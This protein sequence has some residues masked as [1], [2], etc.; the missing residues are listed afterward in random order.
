[1]LG[2]Y[3][4]DPAFVGGAGDNFD[5]EGKIPV[6]IT[7]IAPVKASA[8]NGPIVPGDLLTSSS[9]PGHAMK[10]GAVTIDEVTFHR[11]GTILGKALEPLDEGTGVISVLVALQ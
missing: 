7:G 3:S 10:A 8:E 6:G 11:P 4:T 5:I 9:L 1:M 2:V